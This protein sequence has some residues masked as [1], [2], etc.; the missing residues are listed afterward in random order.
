MIAVASLSISVVTQGHPSQ[1]CIFT[2][3]Y[4]TLAIVLCQDICNDNISL[5][6][7]IGKLGLRLMHDAYLSELPSIYFSY[8]G[9]IGILFEPLQVCHLSR[10][11]IYLLVLNLTNDASFILR[12]VSICIERHMSILSKLEI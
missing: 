5:G 9:H 7:R 12:P 6:H 11:Y 1:T 4:V 2:A 8:Y 3:A 10:M